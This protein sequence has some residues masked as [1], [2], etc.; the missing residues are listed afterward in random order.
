MNIQRVISVY[1]KRTQE[2]KEEIVIDIISLD[3]LKEIF[4]SKSDDP[5]MY[6]PYPIWPKQ[7]KEINKLLATKIVFDF[8]DNFYSVECYQLPPYELKP[9][10]FSDIKGERVI[11]WQDKET[12]EFVS[13]YRIDELIDEQ[14]LR[15][16]FSPKDND[17]MLY[18]E[19]VITPKEAKEL[20]K[21]VNFN[22]NFNKFNYL[23]DCY[24]VNTEDERFMEGEK[25][26]NNLIRVERSITV[27]SRT[28]EFIF[29]HRIDSEITIE[30]LKI[31]FEPYQDDPLMLWK[32][33]KY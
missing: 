13:Q 29:E 6:D 17:P 14:V 11:S 7:A 27:Y 9:L 24:Q 22:F 1:S 20:S 33:L 30:Q 25:E 8:I 28:G 2:L 23:L 3:Q 31:I 16:I 12:E 18:S 4:I 19:Y 10:T 5:L 32:L 15:S 21:Y 26:V